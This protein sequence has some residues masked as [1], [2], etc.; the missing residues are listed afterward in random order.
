M[1]GFGWGGRINKLHDQAIFPLFNPNEMANKDPA[2]VVL[3][4]PER[5][6]YAAR[7]K[8]VF[9]QNLFADP[10]TALT[11]AMYAI[12]RFEPED[13]SFHHTPSKFDC[14][15][16]STMQLTAQELR[17]KELFTNPAGGNCASCHIG[18]PKVNGAH[19]RFKDFNFQ[20]LGE[21][22]NDELP[23]NA[24]PKYLDMSLGPMRTDQS[25]EKA[26]CRPSSL[27][28]CA[29]RRHVA[30]SSITATFTR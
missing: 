17:G 30:C 8:D 13:P 27:R 11:Q 2:A 14:Y 7:L 28:R 23:A 25:N 21:A 1:G 26:N 6:S 19:P 18:Q 3:A 5:A 24:D 12:D 9:G 22:R 10:A 4:K 20:A 15:H 29:I 16:D